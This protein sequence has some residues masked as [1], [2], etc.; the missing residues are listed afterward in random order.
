LDVARIFD[1]LVDGAPG[2]STPMD[3]IS[4][5][6]PELV[7]AGVAIDRLEAF[8][9]TLHP[10]IVGRSF[11]WEPGK[12][13]LVRENKYAY[14]QSPEFLESPVAEVFKT[15]IGVRRQ[16]DAVPEDLRAD[17]FVD[18]YAGPLRFMNGTNHAI[19]FASRSAFSAEALAAIDSILR[20]L[21][22]VAEILALSRTAANLLNTYVGHNAGERILAGNIQRG[23]TS[24]ISAV[25]W[26][27]DLRDFTALSADL[28]PAGI[29]R[30]LNEL[31]D[32]QVPAIER[33]GGEVL[34]FIGDGL[35]AIFPLAGK[36]AGVVCDGA[37]AA[38]DEAFAA[39]AGVNQTR[40]R[41]IRFG[42]ALHVG[43]VAYGNIGGSSRL[44]FTCIG[45]A[46]NLAARL[47]G[48]TSKLG[49]PVVTSSDFARLTSRKLTSLGTF[50]LKGVV[51]ATEAFAVD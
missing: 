30:V 38:S 4:K 20:P 50:E 8:V 1:W 31:F 37:L 9:R 44:D 5:M 12:A 3:V 51:E 35:L 41:P 16:G 26:F 21:S 18:Y 36:D 6:A 22:R 17:G 10:H 40:E 48:L 46:V 11:V 32:C 14:L 33:H 27:S 25:L 34:K 7:A 28:G 13:V 24:S 43:D 23:D 2:T 19:A 39:L 47:E 45:P 42:L 15:G 29:I 49:K